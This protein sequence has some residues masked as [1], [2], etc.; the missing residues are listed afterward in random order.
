MVKCG[1]FPCFRPKLAA[2]KEASAE[3]SAQGGTAQQPLRDFFREE[4]L[5]VLGNLA[6]RVRV[7]IDRSLPSTL[8][9]TSRVTNGVPLAIINPHAPDKRYVILH[10]LMHHQLDELGCPSLC[11]TLQA[12]EIPERSW[13]RRTQFQSFVRG[14]LVQLWELIQH[15]RFNKMIF[16][17][18]SCGPESARDKEYRGYMASKSL[19]TYAMCRSDG[20]ASL[21][22]VA[23]AAHI[24]TVMLEGSKELQRDFLEFVRTRY[25]AGDD[26]V[27]LGHK[28]LQCVRPCDIE[29][30]KMSRQQLDALMTSMLEDLTNMLDTLDTGLKVRVGG[31]QPLK[32]KFNQRCT[33]GAVL[34]AA[35]CAVVDVPRRVVLAWMR[36]ALRILAPDRNSTAVAHVDFCDP[37]PAPNVSVT[38]GGFG[39][40]RGPRGGGGVGS[41]FGNDGAEFR[42]ES[43]SQGLG[44]VQGAGFG[45]GESLGARCIM[46][47]RRD[48]CACCAVA[49]SQC[50]AD[51]GGTGRGKVRG[52]LSKRVMG[53]RRVQH[54]DLSVGGQT[55]PGKDA[56]DSSRA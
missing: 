55:A 54:C 23:I 14:L 26:M 20:H 29:L 18:F 36:V 38:A 42:G 22:K 40:A 47:D 8:H 12:K 15:S 6:D 51:E 2:V 48:G 32:E 4:E 9:G 46:L 25:P 1:C 52:W 17:V 41:Q 50:V 13:L 44:L 11:C 34:C 56:G 49:G 19:P 35:C 3:P 28:M 27:A 45:I 30:L 39:H 10:E 33:T 37:R 31:V 53:T 7:V 16:R 21:K 43:M 24:A 5:L